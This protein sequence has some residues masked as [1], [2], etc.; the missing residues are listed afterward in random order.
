M[1]HSITIYTEYGVAVQ[2]N[3]VT[4]DIALLS[5]VIGLP[6]YINDKNSYD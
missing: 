4:M 3:Y 1:T 2:I 6:R 5:F